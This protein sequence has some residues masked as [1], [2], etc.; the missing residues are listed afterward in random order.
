MSSL[1]GSQGG[2][3]ASARL[4]TEV[5]EEA[6]VGFCDAEVEAVV[7]ANEEPTLGG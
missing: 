6:R 2:S 5:R 4:V 3:T 7:E 1:T